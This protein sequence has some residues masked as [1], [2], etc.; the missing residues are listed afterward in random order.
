MTAIKKVA[1]VYK[2]AAAHMV[3]DG[4]KVQNLFPNGNRM[5]GKQLS[6]FF[7]LDYAAPSYFPPSD[8]PRGVEEHPHRGFETVTIAYQGA[9]QHRDSG[10]NAG[11]IGPGD[12]QWM[13]AASGVVHEEKHDETFTKTGGTLE[14]VQLWVNLPRAHKMDKPR[15]QS[16]LNENIPVVRYEDGSYVRVIAGEFEGQPGAAKTFTPL[17]LFDIQLKAGK[18]IQ[19]QLPDGYNTG[20]VVMKGKVNINGS[21]DANGVE[22]A[23]FEQAGEQ[24]TITALEDASLLLLNGEPIRESIFAYGPF[25]MNTKEE[26]ITAIDDFNNG[27]MGRL[28]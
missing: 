26:I 7:L 22:I 16:L 18:T 12:V 17:N 5:I 20:L 9:L 8:K 15:Y 10:G 13:T 28:N 11:R 14:M 4:F 21:H 19:L 3:G 24:I 23:V 2:G 1:H 25:V 27:K 6:P